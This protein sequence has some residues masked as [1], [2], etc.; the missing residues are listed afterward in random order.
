GLGLAQHTAQFDFNDIERYAFDAN[1]AYWNNLYKL[2]RDTDNMIVIAKEKNNDAYEA[3]GLIM[4]SYLASQLTDLWGNVPY[5]R[6]VKGKT[7]QEFTPEYTTQKE[8]YLEEGGILANL[9]TANDLLKNTKS[10]IAGDIYYNGN[11]TKW[12]KFANSLRIRYLMR[13]SN[14]VDEISELDLKA[15][16]QNILS[17]EPLFESNADN[18]LLPFLAS[19]PNQFDLFSVRE[20]DFNLF[21][22]SNTSESILNQLNDPRM[23]IWFRPT[24]A[25]V[26]AGSDAY[27]GMPVGLLTGTQSEL[28]IDLTKISKLG[29]NYRE[30]P[31]ATDAVI[32]NYS[33]LQFLLAEAAHKGLIA[34][35]DA[36]AENY[37]KQGIEASFDYYGVEMPDTYLTQADVIYDTSKAMNL[38]MT[39]KW[40]ANFLVG[41]EAWL[42][43]KRTGYPA[44][45][46]LLD[47]ANGNIIPSRYR[48]PAEEQAYNNESY[49]NA[50][51]TLSGED[52]INAK[53]WWEE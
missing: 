38:I 35:G 18:A 33:E 42:D 14:K 46:P 4:K 53:L 8:I 28:G 34:G 27:I 1:Q 22:M 23:Y 11:L 5:H 51:Q 39:Q 6:A 32:M 3:V 50:L 45:K 10:V 7:D 2:L 30:E 17:N 31:D 52:D 20:G 43:F 40:L 37:Y 48:Y 24:E 44:L 29:T 26:E 36:A 47:N 9:K 41:Y 25:S 12:R 49:T 21:R 15:E 19:K 13:L 16:L